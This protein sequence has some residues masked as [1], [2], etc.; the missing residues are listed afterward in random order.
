MWRRLYPLLH[1]KGQISLLSRTFQSRMGNSAALLKRGRRTGAFFSNSFLLFRRVCDKPRASLKLAE[2]SAPAGQQFTLPYCF[3]LSGVRQKL[4]GSWSLIWGDFGQGFP[5]IAVFWKD[6][7]ILSNGKV[8]F[9][10]LLLPL[11]DLE[12]WHAS[13]NL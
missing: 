5:P 6:S 12:Y 11:A 1:T 7:R 4:E 13:P 8:L 3:L 9:P 2:N 10:V